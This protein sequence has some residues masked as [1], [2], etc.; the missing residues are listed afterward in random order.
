MG[1]YDIVFE[2]AQ[3]LIDIIFEKI[4]LLVVQVDRDV[5]LAAD[6]VVERVVKHLLGAA[7]L[8][9]KEEHTHLPVAGLIRDVVT[10]SLRGIDHSLVTEMEIGFL[11]GL[12]RDVQQGGK[13]VH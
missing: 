11:D 3:I 1:G 5:R 8:V 13:F 7:E 9:E 10:F 6:R 2:L 12:L 4:D